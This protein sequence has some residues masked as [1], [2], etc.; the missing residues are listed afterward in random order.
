VSKSYSTSTNPLGLPTVWSS[1][2]VPHEDIE[3]IEVIQG[4]QVC[5]LRAVTMKHKTKCWVV[6]QWDGDKE[7]KDRFYTYK[8]G[9][10]RGQ[11][12]DLIQAIFFELRKA[13]RYAKEPTEGLTLE[14]ILDVD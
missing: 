4:N 8:E 7:L 1:I 2:S 9:T 6:L 11:T 13:K 12:D 3:K 5:V 10:G 14:G